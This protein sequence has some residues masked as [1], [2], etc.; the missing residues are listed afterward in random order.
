[1]PTNNPEYQKRYRDQH[2]LD[3]KQKYIDQASAR[4]LAL[5]N[6]VWE[7]KRV[8]CLDCGRSY[9]PWVMHFDHRPGETKVGNIATMVRN[10]QR[11]KV[12]EE[13]KKCDIVCAN[14][15]ADRTYA[16][17]PASVV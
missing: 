10:N 11:T 9:N 2:Y 1:M 8:P 15:H 12:F 7:L 4:K 5:R 3:N 14:C 16:R 17:R 13:I 6:E